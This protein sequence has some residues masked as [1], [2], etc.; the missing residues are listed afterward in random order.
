MQV[1]QALPTSE[2]LGLTRCSFYVP[3]S[4]YNNGGSIVKFIFNDGTIRRGRALCHRPNVR[5]SVTSQLCSSERANTSSVAH[6]DRHVSQLDAASQPAAPRQTTIPTTNI[7]RG[8][9]LF[10]DRHTPGYQVTRV[11]HTTDSIPVLATHQGTAI[12]LALVPTASCVPHSCLTRPLQPLR[13]NCSLLH[14]NAAPSTP[15]PNITT[16]LLC[17]RTPPRVPPVNAPTGNPRHYT[18]IPGTRRIN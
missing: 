17:P 14:T 5:Q 4:S 15:T 10:A 6:Q 16:S 9:P 1:L 3:R 12:L 18:A 2:G 13:A 11:V 8:F 7:A